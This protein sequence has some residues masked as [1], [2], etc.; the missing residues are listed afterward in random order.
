MIRVKYPNLRDEVVEAVRALSD[1]EYQQRV[2]VR[3]EVSSEY[4]DEFAHRIHM[5]YD[6]TKVLEDPQSA[7]GDVLASEE[8]ACVMQELA[9]VLD[10]LFGRVGTD[11]SDDEYLELPEWRTVVATARR[12]L[13]TLEG[14]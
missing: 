1:L 9:D 14:S 3:R 10:S 5:L 2:W 4:Y 6:D 7:V 11:L 13:I 12:A 8:E